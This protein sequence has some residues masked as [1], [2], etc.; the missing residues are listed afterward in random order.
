MLLDLTYCLF[1][2]FFVF[3]SFSCIG[4]YFSSKLS[5]DNSS[6]LISYFIGKS[7]FIFNLV[8]FYNFLNL[9]LFETNLIFFTFAFICF[10]LLTIKK[11][12]F[13]KKI[14]VLFFKFYFPI[15]F[16]L[17]LITFLYEINFYVFRGNH[18][19]WI[20]QISMGL[21]FNEN[22]YQ[23]FLK[24]ANFELSRNIVSLKNQI[25]IPFE[26]SYYFFSIS[27]IEIG[28]RLIPSQL[29]GSFF[30]VK[31]LN[32]F[33]LAF[34]LKVLIF[35]SIFPAYYYFL[36]SFSTTISKLNTYFISFVFSISTWSFYLFENDALAQLIVFSLSI[37]F[38]SLILKIFL[39]KHQ[40]KINLYLLSIVASALF[41]T[42][43]EQAI[44]IMFAGFLFFLIHLR[45][46]F[47][48][49][50]FYI[51]L[52]IFVIL[53]S[54][55]LIE[56]INLSI[57]M[58]TASNDWWG[59][60]GSYLLGKENLVLDKGSVLQI[61]EIINNQENSILYKLKNIFDLHILNGYY[62][63]P[64]TIIPSLVGFY[65]LSNPSFSILNLLFLVPFNLII[66]YFLIKNLKYLLLNNTNELKFIK[67]FTTFS[68]LLIII[69]AFRNQLYI[70]IKL[71]YFFSLFFLILIFINWENNLSI[72]KLFLILMLIFPIYK[73]SDY[74]S[75]NMRLD[76]F[77]SSLN[78]N[79]K[80]N[81]NF[82][83]D[84]KKLNKCDAIDL[85]IDDQIANLYVSLILDHKKINYFNNTRFANQNKKIGILNRI[86]CLVD[87][88]NKKIDIEMF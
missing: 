33:L 47:L 34:T 44:V 35:S 10:I 29:L 86:N 36:N 50:D 27:G 81:L 84:L 69:F 3:I 78:Q 59:Y 76:S 79:I 75:G 19:D 73:F 4:F 43:P 18:W 64:L 40:N 6:Y 17:F 62:L 23:E 39:E 52:G 63:I 15:I 49:N 72:N 12:E 82:K 11:R 70:S 8:L 65:F 46:I 83:F 20:S 9:S 41:L 28:H 61:K 68:V 21:V 5:Q 71:I 80:K 14:L 57:N 88:K 45:S 16:I 7:F 74:N 56:Y 48:N 1:L 30:L 25:G 58:S 38:F 37:V 66:I 87:I 31:N 85:R 22:D 2:I 51:A 42:Y 32:I 77:P 53:I 13:L 26:K 60:F 24:I 55:D 67:F 54:K